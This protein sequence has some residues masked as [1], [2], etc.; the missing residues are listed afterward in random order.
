MQMKVI[1]PVATD[2]IKKIFE[3]TLVEY[4]IVPG[5]LVTDNV[6]LHNNSNFDIV[7]GDVNSASCGELFILKK[8]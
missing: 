2:E 5:N 7:F 8:K 4:I 6:F 3:K 1:H